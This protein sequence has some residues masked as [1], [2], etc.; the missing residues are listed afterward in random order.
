MTHASLCYR[1]CSPPSGQAAH[2]SSQAPQWNL[3]HSQLRHLA[4]CLAGACES[5]SYSLHLYLLSVPLLTLGTSS[6]CLLSLVGPSVRGLSFGYRR[7]AWGFPPPLSISLP[8]PSPKPFLCRILLSVP[9]AV[10]VGLYS[11]LNPN[12]VTVLLQCLLL[13]Y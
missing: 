13:V 8:P 6:F 7:N 3:L 9:A 2:S 4:D 5:S 12:C 10:G 11:N 1:V